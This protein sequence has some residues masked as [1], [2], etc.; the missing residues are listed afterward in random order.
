M[1]DSSLLRT[2]TEAASATPT[3]EEEEPA[4]LAAPDPSVEEEEEPV[5]S[6]RLA[7]FYA[8]ALNVRSGLQRETEKNQRKHAALREA[9]GVGKV[10]SWYD[11]HQSEVLVTAKTQALQEGADGD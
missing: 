9:V 7:A 11:E 2:T 3:V 6:E 8:R 4:R 10:Q 1:A 5:D